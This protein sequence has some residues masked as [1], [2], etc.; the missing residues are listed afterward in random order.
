[1]GNKVIGRREFCEQCG[2]LVIGSSCSNKN[3]ENCIE[4]FQKPTS[5]QKEYLQDLMQKLDINEDKYPF[6]NMTK[7]E[8]SKLIKKLAAEVEIKELCED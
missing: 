7:K 8:A 5:K 4:V 1:M 2:S 6:V 3:C